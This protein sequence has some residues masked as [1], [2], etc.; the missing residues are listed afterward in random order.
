ML[1]LRIKTFSLPLFILPEIRR[2]FKRPLVFYLK[3]KNDS[4]SFFTTLVIMDFQK[5]KLDYAV[6]YLPENI[7]QIENHP[8]SNIFRINL[9]NTNPHCTLKIKES[10][11]LT[12]V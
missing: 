3:H 4:R 9:S 8:R 7:I 5:E 11:F 2:S 1:D 10:S 12:F 6:S